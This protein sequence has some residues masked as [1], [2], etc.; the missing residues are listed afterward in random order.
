M[1]VTLLD[2]ISEGT[3]SC[4]LVRTNL[5]EYI[6]HL[7]DDFEDYFVQRGIVL[8]R[9]LENLWDT[10]IEERHIPSIVLN[11]MG[12]VPN[13]AS[14]RNINIANDYRILDGLQRTKR[15]KVIWETYLL[16]GQL[17]NGSSD[18]APAVLARRNS[19]KIKEIGS[20]TR[21]FSQI[22]KDKRAD[23]DLEL[24]LSKNTIWLELWIG[25]D[26]ADQIRKMLI[27]NAGHKSVSI[28]HQIELLF[29]DYL[30]IFQSELG[31]LTISREKEISSISYSKKREP[32]HYHF[33]HLISAFESLNAASPITTNADYSAE[34]TFSNLPD[35][36]ILDVDPALLK[37]FA[38]SLKALDTSFEDKIGAQWIGREVVIS[39]IFAA[40]GWFAL[41]SKQERAWA[42]DQFC[43]RTSQLREVAN[44]E[45][46]EAQRNRLQL[47]KVNIG[48]KNRRAVYSALRD[49]LQNE[50]PAPIDWESAFEATDRKVA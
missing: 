49:F 9:Y 45:E 36:E 38:K 34:R 46:F 44:L 37:A 12:D 39:S 32:G 43:G 17:M 2:S 3:A 11:L 50:N 41:H 30:D 18:A 26:Q 27:L 4:L 8:N 1:Q 5:L 10:L 25:L 24:L 21:L 22:L 33:P 23:T 42:L 7:P 28:K 29:I 35:I 19:E 31:D 6:M 15:L 48:V 14:G 20:N 13:I 16:V 40:V 47:S